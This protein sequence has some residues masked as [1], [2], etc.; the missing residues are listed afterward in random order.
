GMRAYFCVH[1]GTPSARILDS[2]SSLAP[3]RAGE[4]FE[5]RSAVTSARFL[6]ANT[7]WNEKPLCLRVLPGPQADWCDLPAFLAASY[8]GTPAITRMGLRLVGPPLALPAREIVSE[9]VCPGAV[10][11]TRDGQCIILGIDGQTIGG[12]P[13]VAQVITTDLDKLAQLRP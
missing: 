9:P 3:V 7:E 11:V 12:Y 2:C 6:A 13:K 1:G 5:C 4:S 8:Q 10:Q